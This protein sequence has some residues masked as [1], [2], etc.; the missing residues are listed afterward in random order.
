MQLNFNEYVFVR[1]TSHGKDYLEGY[2]KRLWD[3]VKLPPD[4]DRRI[5]RNL[6][7]Y[8]Y[9]VQL[10]ELMHIFGPECYMG[11]PRAMFV[12]NL[13]GIDVAER[14]QKAPDASR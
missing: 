3:S 12:D 14:R 6:D 2:F 7:G 4:D 5:I 8:A 9:K 11:N 1:L 13:I 10:W